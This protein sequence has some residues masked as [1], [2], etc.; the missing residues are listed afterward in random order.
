M[1]VLGRII[2]VWGLASYHNVHQKFHIS[3]WAI[4]VNKGFI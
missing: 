2:Q 4:Y 3:A 1:M